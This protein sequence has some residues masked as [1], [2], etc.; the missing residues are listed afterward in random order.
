MEF[1]R[2]LHFHTKKRPSNRTASFPLIRKI[3]AVRATSCFGMPNPANVYAQKFPSLN[4]ITHECEV[5]EHMFKCLH[6]W[7]TVLSAS[8]IPPLK[9]WSN[10]LPPMLL[11]LP[12]LPSVPCGHKQH[13]STTALHS[14]RC[15]QL[16]MYAKYLMRNSSESSL[17]FNNFVQRHINSVH[18][19][20]AHLTSPTTIRS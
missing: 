20:A 8:G 16:Q 4:E 14:D 15:I 13:P 6:S 11:S 10:S 2:F 3:L 7:N 18:K 12:I 1:S 17:F 9:L 19:G 5:K